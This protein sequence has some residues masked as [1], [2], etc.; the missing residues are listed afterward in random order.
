MRR[1][2]PVLVDAGAEQPLHFLG[3]TGY[4]DVRLVR[5]ELGSARKGLPVPANECFPGTSDQSAKPPAERRIGVRLRQV[6]GHSEA[7]PRQ[8]VD[9]GGAI[10]TR[11]RNP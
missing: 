4:D 11:G 8:A 7:F 1:E 3:S 2:E 5:R 10:T 9:P 6:P